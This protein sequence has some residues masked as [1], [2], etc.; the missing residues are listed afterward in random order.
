MKVAGE[1]EDG[2]WEMG[3]QLIREVEIEFTLWWMY[4]CMHDVGILLALALER[5]ERAL[6]E[7]FFSSSYFLFL[8]LVFLK[9]VFPFVFTPHLNEKSKN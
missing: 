7:F 6:N 1:M 2:R 9:S 3:E 8:S 5:S 4:V